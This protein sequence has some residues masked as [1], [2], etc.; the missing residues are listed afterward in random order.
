MGVYF[1]I[2]PPKYCCHC[3]WSVNPRRKDFK[4]HRSMTCYQCGCGFV[5]IQR[6]QIE[7]SVLREFNLF[8][9]EEIE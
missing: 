9:P 8:H 2:N 4:R 1:N 7:K 6:N 3:G 5:H